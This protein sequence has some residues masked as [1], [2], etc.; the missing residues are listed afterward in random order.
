MEYKEIAEGVTT[1][2]GT[3]DLT[4]THVSPYVGWSTK[5]LDLW[6]S[7]GLGKGEVEIH[8]G[9]QKIWQ[10]DVIEPDE[11]A[12]DASM[13]VDTR[14]GYG[15][16]SLAGQGLFAPYSE[17]T[18]NDTNTYRPGVQRDAGS[19][20][21]LNLAGERSGTPVEHRILLKGEI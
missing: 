6:G 20:L 2:N 1:Q 17:M 4:V 3:H 16:P 8:N 21:S 15:L 7:V 14:T 9:L 13:R 11:T 10:Q 5:R 18:S 12:E 19:V